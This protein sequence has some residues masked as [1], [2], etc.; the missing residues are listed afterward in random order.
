MSIRWSG[1][2]AVIDRDGFCNIVGRIKDMLIRGG[3]NV[4]PREIEDCLIQHPKVQSVQVFGV[5]DD[6]V[7]L[8]VM[9]VGY[10]AESWEAGGQ[11]PR[12]PF[13]ELYFE[14]DIN[15]P[16]KQD[17]AVVEKL[18]AAKMITRPAPLPERR[19]EIMQLAERLNLPT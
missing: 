19:Q 5:P 17:E 3:E 13:E 6:W 16:F 11:R 7:S 10:P 4:Y 2:L 8:W 1:D 9:L 18:K 12:P 15:T 14:G